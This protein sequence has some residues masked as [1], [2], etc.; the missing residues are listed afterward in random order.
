M[1]KYICSSEAQKALSREK[2]CFLDITTMPIFRWHYFDKDEEDIEKIL[3]LMF[4]IS[5]S[6][7]YSLIQIY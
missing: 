2:G 4:V 5:K 7:H 3:T 6:L 1:I